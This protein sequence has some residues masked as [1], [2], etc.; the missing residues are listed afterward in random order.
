L[1]SKS[2]PH[3]PLSWRHVLFWGGLRGAISLA[4]ALSLPTDLA[5]RDTLLAMTFGVVLFS[6]LAQGTSIQVLLK[7][8]GLTQP[9][10]HRV[11][12]EMRLGRLF[13]AQAGLEQLERLYHDGILTDEM[14]AGLRADY[15]QTQEQLIDSMNQLFAQ[16]AELER[17][18]LIKA[19]REA[20]QAERG[21]LADALRRGLISEHT[22]EELYTGVDRRL[23]ALDMIQASIHHG[24]T[25]PQEG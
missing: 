1:W 25:N 23:E 24:W 8:L 4:L 3:I 16:H 2:E 22:Y 20:L 21:A 7:R 19:R 9:S 18:M 11:A 6:L 13:A 5:Q 15:R 17:E 12:Q 14:W 10:E